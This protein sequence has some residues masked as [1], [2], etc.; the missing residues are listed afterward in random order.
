VSTPPPLRPCVT[1]VRAV[2]FDLY[3]TLV[4][5]FPRED[6]FDVVRAMALALGAPVEAFVDAWNDTAIERQ[7]GGFPTIDANVRAICERVGARPTEPAIAEA[8]AVRAAMYDRWFRP[9]PGAVE[10]LE[11]LAE[12]EMPVALVSMCAPDTPALWRSSVLASFVDVTVFS[13]ET[14][15]RKPDP[16]IYLAACDGLGVERTGC[17]YCG[18]GAYGELSGARAVGMTPVLISNPEL[19]PEDA[20]RPEAEVW[21]GPTVDHLLELLR[22]S[23]LP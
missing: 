18:D 12:R 23:D 9:R 15:L 13:S 14:G 4:Y 17:L 16:D 21:D 3:G 19:A 1:T 11:Q 8:L 5:E 2:V 10:I 6:F 7:T 20:L 22:F